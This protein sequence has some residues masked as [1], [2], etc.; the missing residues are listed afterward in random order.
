MT[1]FHLPL[2]PSY[3]P[4]RF[5]AAL[6]L[7]GLATLTAA[8]SDIVDGGE[9]YIVSDYYNMALGIDTTASDTPALTA[10]G[11]VATDGAYVFVAEN[12][13]ADGYYYLR[14]KATGKYL[15]ASTANS[16]SLA[17]KDGK[18][19]G[20]E[21]LWKLDVQMG[22]TISTKKNS[23]KMLGCD[24]SDAAMVRVYYNKS[25]NSTA[26][27]TVVPALEEGYATSL[28]AAETSVFT[29][30]I[31]RKEQDIMQVDGTLDITDTLDIHLMGDRPFTTAGTIDLKN[32]DSWV[33]FD[34]IA[35][36]KV[37]S[38]WLSHILVNGSKAKEGTNVRVAI[39][40]DGAAVIPTR[41]SD[42]PFVGY[43]EENYGGD[44]VALKKGY[45]S[46]LG[47]SNNALRSFTL[48]RGYMAMLCTGQTRGGYTR[49]FVADHADLEVPVM[50]DALNRRVSSIHIKEW[51]YTS[52]KGWCST[53]GNSGIA[54]GTST[55]NAS[56]F[57]TWSADRASTDDCEYVPIRQHV[58]WPSLSAISALDGSTHVLGFNEPDHSEQ[59]ADCDCGGTISAWT[60]TTKMPDMASLPMRIGS[61]APTDLSWLTDFTGHVDD[62]AYRCDYVALHAYWGPN[63]ANGTSAWQSRLKGVWDNTKRPIWITEWAYGA[64]WTTESWP[65]KYS[66]QL[67]KNRAAIFDIVNLLESLPYV[68]R[69]S[70]YQWD[71][72]SR[73]FINDDGWVTP[74][75]KV[76]QK[77]R[78]TFAYNA[79]YQKVPVWWKPSAKAATLTAD[80]VAKGMRFAITNANA[81]YT[82]W[83]T[84][85]RYSDKT[86]EWTAINEWADRSKF[87]ASAYTYTLPYDSIDRFADRYRVRLSTI[88][89]EET[90]SAPLD[91]GYIVNADCNDGTTGW[92]ASNLSTS[93]GEA[94]DGDAANAYWNQWK[95]GSL[96]SSMTQTVTAL[97]AG[98]Y[99]LKALV[100]GS[101]NTTL[102][103]RL[104]YATPTATVTRERSL[105]G[106]GNATLEGSP[107]QYGWMAISTDSVEVDEGATLTIELAA[108]AD[109]SAWWSADHVSL[110]YTAPE[111]VPSAV[112]GVKAAAENAAS[113]AFDLGGKRVDAASV[114]GLYIQEGK[115]KVR[116]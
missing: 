17:W 87:D 39:Y 64:S 21:Y 74:A 30:D 43:T 116:K 78:S 95:S 49:V 97:P 63:E 20:D 85:E 54:G 2:T 1:N 65:S 60:A 47:T 101:A 62:M 22:R 90:T 14:S 114:R 42:T 79:S 91:L 71:T 104:T 77:T 31:G 29:N 103:A 88:Y 70:Y 98:Q 18:G 8:A 72:S 115:K 6:G 102:T 75:G 44:K 41:S 50:P 36:S 10:Y 16:W 46:S 100:R 59:H 94:S 68:E 28:T 111:P 3:S 113:P 109:G 106:Q 11:K 13:T 73:R 38:L 93:K 33:I 92:T 99:C 26:R 55:M 89:G 37:K 9:Y 112:V 84:L 57:Y 107:Y 69:Y 12:S 25:Y 32:R 35:P 83:M 105:A 45:K 7:L 34:H 76:Y 58:Y 23:S 66:D 5:L 86:G 27:F 48:K 61:P 56:W 81:D 19:T 82:E 51:Q 108:Q 52:K 96:N 24:W 4:S 40:L 53:Q 15:T 80:S 67:E 110:G